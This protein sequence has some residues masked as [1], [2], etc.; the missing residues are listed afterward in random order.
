MRAPTSPA[1]LDTRPDRRMVIGNRRPLGEE[2][3]ES[4][5]SGRRD[6]QRQPNGGKMSHR[7]LN[8]LVSHVVRLCL[9][10]LAGL[11]V[12]AG[13]NSQT[14]QPPIGGLG[15]PPDY[16]GVAPVEETIAWADVIAR[17][18]LVSVTAVAEQ[19]TGETDYVAALDYRFRVLE[20]LRGSG[21]SELVAV[22]YDS[23]ETFS[24]SGSA[25]TRAQALKDRRDTQWDSMEAIIFLE[26]AHPALPSS[27]Q[28]D[29]YRL[30]AESF[31]K[32][33]EDYYTI[34][35]RWDKKW[36][37]AASSGAARTSGG[38]DTQRFLLDAPAASSGAGGAVGQPRAVGQSGIAPTITLSDLRA[39]VAANAAAIPAGGGSEA[40]KD[41]LYL[42]LEWAREV[43]FRVDL[44]GGNYF[45]TRSDASLNSGLAAG[46]RA[47]TDPYTVW[48]P[49]TPPAWAGDYPIIGRDAALFRTKWP[50]VADTVRPLPAGEY[51][52]YFDHR[53][54]EAI[55]CDAVPD[56]EKQRQEVFVTV[57]APTGTLHEAFFDPITLSG[58]RVGATGSSGV[59]DPEEFAVGSVE[60]EI[61]SLVWGANSVVLELD[62]YVSLSGQTLDFIELNG[63]IDTSLDVA[64]ATV[65]QTAATW[66]WSVTGAPWADGDLLM[67][68][69]RDTSTGP[70][71]GTPTPTAT[72]TPGPT[73]TPTATPTPVPPTA[74][75][76]PVSN[77]T[78]TT[79]TDVASYS[80]TSGSWSASCP[81]V[82]RP[83]KH[84]QYYTFTLSSSTYLRIRLN[85][86]QDTYL[87]LLS[88]RG[89]GGSVIA[90][91][92]NVTGFVTAPNDNANGRAT[93]SL[94]SRPFAAGTY[95]VE[96]TTRNTVTGSFT[97][98][99]E[100]GDGVGGNTGA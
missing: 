25:V 77:C 95:T 70:T 59:I 51:K 93:N 57:T 5:G 23:G 43:Q 34:A 63:S 61:E 100:G 74:T 35:S 4:N 26:D 66:T 64:D 76:N 78:I 90:A 11:I 38:S 33:W 88:G 41:C 82:N 28:A 42:K 89:T 44:R 15:S 84:A 8:R 54:K 75:P 3:K 1:R 31:Y 18:Q 13:C 83:G 16:Y 71:V 65:N 47:F 46:T 45:Y 29:R 24:G 49:E 81:S 60:Y 94:I 10:A 98:I 14:E 36:L 9:L 32:A 37:P 92:D 72:P 52:F 40:Y 91:N 55:I 12:F 97:L 62:D 30:G 2:P 69:I 48:A 21:G 17:V 85:S 79:L 86:S 27:S 6:L 58:S 96:A 67:L 56:L 22:A 39:K 19:K 73:A 87:Y 50:G 68:R 20:Y 53:P 7:K 99:V 80:R